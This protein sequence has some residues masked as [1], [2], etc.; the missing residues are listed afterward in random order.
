MIEWLFYASKAWLF[1][2]SACQGI[3]NKP[4]FIKLIQMDCVITIVGLLSIV[5]RNDMG[6]HRN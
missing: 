4:H 1:R 6:D 3:H 5:E 2:P